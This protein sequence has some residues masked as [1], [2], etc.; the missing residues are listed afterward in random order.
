MAR[1]K[2][3][4]DG[5][6]YTKKKSRSKAFAPQSSETVEP[7]QKLTEQAR[8]KKISELCE[9]MEA[10]DRMMRCLENER[11]KLVNMQKYAQAAQ[12]LEQLSD[13]RKEKR[14]LSEHLAVLQA[15]EAR[16]KAYQAKR[17]GTSKECGSPSPSNK[18][19][20]SQ[21]DDYFLAQPVLEPLDLGQ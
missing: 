14:K 1:K 4:A 8:E 18:G 2:L 11:M 21:I 10:V 7:R 3:D 9:D 15:K 5:Y 12:V 6:N 13:K 17:S 20:S 16:A 19:N